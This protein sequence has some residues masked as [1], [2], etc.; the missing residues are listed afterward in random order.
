MPEKKPPKALEKKIACAMREI[1]KWEE[2]YNLLL[3]V[4]ELL[5]TTLS[6]EDEILKDMFYEH[7]EFIE[8][9]LTGEDTVQNGEAMNPSLHVT[10]E[11]IVQTQISKGDPPE[12][13]EAYLTLLNEKV[14]PHIARHAVGAMLVDVIWYG[15]NKLNKGEKVEG[16][17]NVLYAEKLRELAQQKR[18]HPFFSQEKKE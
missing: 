10:I 1:R 18:N 11:A 13:R 15:W 6:Q 14:D 9:I 4:S 8:E 12:A 7:S 5:G 2:K 3:I 16:N 17:P